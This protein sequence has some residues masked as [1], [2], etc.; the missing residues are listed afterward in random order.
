[1]IS[2]TKSFFIRKL[3]T[4]FIVSLGNLMALKPNRKK[5]L[6]KKPTNQLN[7]LSMEKVE[8][9]KRGS[10]TIV[11]WLH[12]NHTY[13]GHI[14]NP[15]TNTSVHYRTCSSCVHNNRFTVIGTF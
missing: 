8:I 2:S 6:K 15:Y 1:M 12:K 7:I 13:I 5:N 11:L 14:Q 9:H 4:N 10:S 3:P